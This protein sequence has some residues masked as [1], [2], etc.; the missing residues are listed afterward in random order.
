MLA[1]I[2][3]VSTGIGHACAEIFIKS[4]DSVVGT[5]RKIEDG[6]KLKNAWGPN[7]SYLI[8]DL[9]DL[10]S[11]DRIPEEL[12]KRSIEH[13]DILVNNSGIAAGGPFLL[14]NF[15]EVEQVIQ[16]NVLG[17]MKVTQVLLPWLGA[18]LNDSFHPGKIINISSVA[19]KIGTPFLAAYV[20]SKHAVEGFSHSLRRELLPFG[21]D[22]V[23]VG[24]G[25]V[26]TPIWQKG[27]RE[28]AQ[29]YGRSSYASIIQNFMR[30][31]LDGEKSGLEVQIIAKLVWEI[32]KGKRKKVRY[33]VVPNL[34][35]DWVIPRLLP[36]RL[37][38]KVVSR[39]L[40]LEKGFLDKG[41]HPS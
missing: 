27:L 12:K 13:I 40:R 21:V 25:T 10:K 14:Q 38:D 16:V 3:G 8:L 34:I 39:V 32:A 20:A 17:L 6:E 19:G 4:G 37:L 23:I 31:A 7:F 30:I 9:S 28:I 35:F 5:V 22:V 1:F 41:S 26:K 2:T 18:Q 36:H 24:P 11:V 29:R 15:S 33:A